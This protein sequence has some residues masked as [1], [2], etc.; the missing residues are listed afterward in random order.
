MIAINEII[1]RKTK[2]FS[3]YLCLSIFVV[4]F[5]YYF[6]SGD[7]GL[8]RF[9]ELKKQI[10]EA[11][12]ILS[13]KSEVRDKLAHKVKLLSSESLDLDLLEERARIVLNLVGED[14]LILINK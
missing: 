2:H 6:M 11:E 4:Y 1:L 12:Q 5:G 10:K 3:I 9:F 14:E 7:R 8:H 13:E